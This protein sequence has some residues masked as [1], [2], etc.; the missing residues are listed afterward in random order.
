MQPV[1]QVLIEAKIEGLFEA[2]SIIDR[3]NAVAAARFIL[4]GCN[5]LTQVLPDENEHNRSIQFMQ[6]FLVQF[7]R[8]KPEVLN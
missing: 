1:S 7:L 6:T 5:G 3:N 2:D 8:L 4:Y